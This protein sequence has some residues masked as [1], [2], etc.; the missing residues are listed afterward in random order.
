VTI[1]LVIPLLLAIALLQAT[2]VPHLAIWGVFPD[3]PLI[4]VASW[5]LL[6]GPREGLTWGFVAG[7]AIDLFA[8]APFGAATLSLT[9][10]G[11]LS[12]LGATSAL[13][14]RL[15]LPMAFVFLA[16][17]LYDVLFLLMV[18]ISGQF[19]PWVE[20]VLRIILPSAVLNALL[21]PV[22]IELLRII[23]QRLGR[24][25]MEL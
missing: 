4:I 24:E 25:E 12:G 11:L 7:I 5:G 8:G 17:L 3:L 10:I 21:T 18:Q 14:T 23:H 19:V 22:F 1:Y 2:I 15:I 13:R 9:V 20:N 16:T 6:R